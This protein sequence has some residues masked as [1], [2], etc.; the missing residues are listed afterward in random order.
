MY[1]TVN[2]AK[3]ARTQDFVREYLVHLSDIFLGFVL[4]SLT[5][6]WIGIIH[7]RTFRQA[8]VITSWQADF[9]M[10]RMDVFCFVS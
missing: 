6:N 4:C 2:D 5:L 10:L 9:V 8:S 1:S 3:L 7:Y